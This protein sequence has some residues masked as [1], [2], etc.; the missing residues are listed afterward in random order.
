[1]FFIL[2]QI[3]NLINNN[4]YVGVHKTD[5]IDDG[6]MGSGKLI[7]LAITK[8]G[9]HNFK[10]EILIFFKNEFEMYAAEKH[11]VNEEWINR[12]DTYNIRLGGSGGFDHINNNREHYNKLW[13]NW[14]NSLTDDERN[15]L[16]EKKANYGDKNGMFGSSRT[17]ELNPMWGKKQTQKCKDIVSQTNRGK[18]PV[19]NKITGEIIGSVDI[20]HPNI[21][22]GEWVSINLGKTASDETRKKMSYAAKRRNTKPPSSKGKLW[23][24]NGIEQKRQAEHPGDGWIRGRLKWRNTE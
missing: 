8:Y 19:K 17:G 2:Y 4:I 11:F 23:W 9:A 10:K 18:M 13:Y 1:M 20:N 3:T 21:I 5:N 12:S 16:N 22:S 7:K 24:N 14:W 15:S 6:Y